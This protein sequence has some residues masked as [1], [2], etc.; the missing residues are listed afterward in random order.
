M[1]GYITA[2]A[3]MSISDGPWWDGMVMDVG[4]G[5]SAVG[6]SGARSLAGFR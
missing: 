5:G 4:G 1:A 2:T 6:V 3:T